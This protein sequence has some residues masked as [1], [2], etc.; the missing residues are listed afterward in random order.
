MKSNTFPPQEIRKR[1]S[2]NYLDLVEPANQAKNKPKRH[3]SYN[4]I[5]SALYPLRSLPSVSSAGGA[6]HDAKRFSMNFLDTIGDSS[7]PQSWQ[8]TMGSQNGGAVQRRQDP[9]HMQGSKRSAAGAPQTPSGD[10]IASIDE[11]LLEVVESKGPQAVCQSPV[12][13][14]LYR[15][16]NQLAAASGDE[17]IEIQC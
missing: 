3:S 17:V 8:N 10:V 12:L 2:M 5:A 7:D 6:H 4:A 13:L 16:R 9:A 15:M 1:F 14:R 11:L